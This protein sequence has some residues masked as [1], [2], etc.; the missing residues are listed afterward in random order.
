VWQK[1]ARRVLRSRSFAQ[2]RHLAP[3][4]AR[5]AA[6][7]VVGEVY[8]QMEQ[9]FGVLPPPMLLHAASPPVLAAAWNLLR[10][11]LLVQ[12]T[13]TRAEKEAVMVAVSRANR[14]PYCVSMHSQ[15]LDG[16][17]SGLGPGLGAS[18][19]PNSGPIRLAEVE[20]WASAHT[21]GPAEP[22]AATTPAAGWPAGLAAE[23]TGVLA[24]MQYLNRMVSLFLGDLPLPP[25]TPTAAMSVVGPVLL[26]LQ[27]YAQRTPARPGAALARLPAAATNSVLARTAEDPVLAETF[28]RVEAAVDAAGR[29]SVPGAV[30]ELVEDRLAGWDGTP[31]GL[32]R[33]W[34]A[35]D[36]ATLPE[37][38]RPAARLALLTAIAAYQADDAVLADYRATGADDAALVELTA[39][40][41]LAAARRIGARVALPGP[42]RGRPTA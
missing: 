21:A 10:E 31:P 4:P 13:A 16:L 38:D 12:R 8:H 3:V 2:I 1:P 9:E 29:R 30:R 17:I 24:M 35:E 23:L 37:T 33:G 28:A 40:S 14:C 15:M 32:G 5:N 26:R 18:L 27:L 7:P 19:R 36:T 39:W 11:T 34:L 25:G 41:A 22:S 6:D 20:R 42:A